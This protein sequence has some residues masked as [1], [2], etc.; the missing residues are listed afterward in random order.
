MV[1]RRAADQSTPP[2][3]A[4][5][6][7]VDVATVESNG[8]TDGPSSDA[9]GDVLHRIKET[10]DATYWLSLM[11]RIREIVQ[12]AT[13]KGAAILVVGSADDDLMLLPGRH[14]KPFPQTADGS[15]SRRYILRGTEVVSQLEQLRLTG[16]EFVLFPATSLW[17]LEHY[18]ELREYLQNACTPVFNA[19]WCKVFKLPKSK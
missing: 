16:A 1:F 19:E 10:V 15:F 18:Q 3:S 6:G 13:P 14:A 12:T 9:L 7:H 5:N 8:P 17:F 11:Q 4:G 2:A